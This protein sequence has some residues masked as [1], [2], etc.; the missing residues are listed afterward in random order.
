M[1]RRKFLLACGAALAGAV[2]K[3]S[4]GQ[5]QSTSA[6]T[7][8]LY[9]PITIKNAVLTSSPN[10]PSFP[11]TLDFLKMADGALPIPLYGPTW[12]VRSGAA[13][14]TPR[15]GTQLTPNGGMESGVSGF[16]PDGVTLA[17]VAGRNGGADKALNVTLS[18]ASGAVQT[19]QAIPAAPG[20]WFHSE[21]WLK[22]NSLA[23]G[24]LPLLNSSGG[25]SL[26][27]FSYN[28]GQPDGNGGEIWASNYA[29]TSWVQ[30]VLTAQAVD[31]GIFEQVSVG[32]TGGQSGVV[33]DFYCYKLDP[34]DLF[35]TLKVAA[36]Y[37]ACVHSRDDVKMRQ[38]G[39]VLN[40]DSPSS[41][42]NYLLA[43]YDR[44]AAQ[45]VV[46]QYVN[47]S[48]VTH[49]PINVV[50]NFA[51]LGLT[52]VKSGSSLDV[53][54]GNTKITTL[55]VNA[56]LANNPYLGM[57]SPYAGG[58]VGFTAAL[59][60]VK[61]KVLCYGD[62]KFARDLPGIVKNLTNGSVIFS[63]SPS[64]FASDGTTQIW[65]VSGQ[66][67]FGAYLN[68]DNTIA[69]YGNTGTPDYIF[70]NLGANDDGHI[71][72]GETT[73][74]QWKQ[75]TAYIL[76]A[77]HAKWPNAKI[78]VARA[79]IRNQLYPEFR[80]YDGTLVPITTGGMTYA[81]LR[82]TW[83]ND[84]LSTRAGWA[85]LGP[86]ERV[87]LQGSDNGATMTQDGVHPN[88]LGCY[89]TAQQWRRAIGFG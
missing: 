67:T 13:S 58:I 18:G 80:K 20:D 10:N 4:G 60:P 65:A 30:R 78:Y 46:D 35:A 64:R 69:D 19:A 57:M 25:A 36:D 63:E 24:L 15:L 74:A 37:A 43:W 89:V 38:Y 11:L 84:I 7:G 17:S 81:N 87:Y 55:T 9:L 23:A 71:Q 33:D 62:S 77:L 68:I 72:L 47:G 8:K 83:L 86:D 85:F 22:N 45:V 44:N 48:R 28:T 76:D 34:K 61:K 3:I 41:P 54:W 5:T 40:C 16:F 32:G 73:E 26:A 31:G 49:T 66:T 42:K 52:A 56:A 53:Y 50:D 51:Y 12:A 2:A 88:N 6:W 79:W 14:N 59:A 29:G 39:L 75:Y 1:N 70:Y 27:V 21:V 82:A